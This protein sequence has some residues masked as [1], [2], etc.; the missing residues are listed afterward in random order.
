MNGSFGIEPRA[1]F[2]GLN[3]RNACG[4]TEAADN[5]PSAPVQNCTDNHVV[6][7]RNDSMNHLESNGLLSGNR[8][9]AGAG[10]PFA[11]KDMV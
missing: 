9:V 4:G 3:F 11:S 7:R 1:C 10:M 8:C 2:Y 6:P 5:F